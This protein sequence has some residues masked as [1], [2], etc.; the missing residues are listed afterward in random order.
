MFCFLPAMF[1][2]VLGPAVVQ[3]VTALGQL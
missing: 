3:L 1:L 2:I